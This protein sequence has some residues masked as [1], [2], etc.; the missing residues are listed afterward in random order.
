MAKSSPTDCSNRLMTNRPTAGPRYCAYAQRVSE[1]LTS[2]LSSFVVCTPT[3][4]FDIGLN[5][6][7]E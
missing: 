2:R 6:V 7:A 5:E 4:F 1:S 3:T